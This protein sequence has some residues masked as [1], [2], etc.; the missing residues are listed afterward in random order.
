MYSFPNYSNAYTIKDWQSENVINLSY[1]RI[2]VDSIHSD[3]PC[4][5]KLLIPDFRSKFGDSTY[6]IIEPNHVCYTSNHIIL[7]S[8]YS[9]SVYFYDYNGNE[10]KSAHLSSKYTSLKI[11]PSTFEE[12]E[13]NPQIINEKCLSNGFVSKIIYDPLRSIY[14]CKARHPAVEDTRPFSLIIMDSNFQK[15]DETAFTSEDYFGSFF[16]GDKGIYILKNTEEK[17]Q[18]SSFTIYNYE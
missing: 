5:Y 15:L 3:N 2:F 10:V 14:Y 7:S 13:E 4:S 17:F 9:D 6:Q 18:K 12:C 8:S 16:I 11:N 1:P